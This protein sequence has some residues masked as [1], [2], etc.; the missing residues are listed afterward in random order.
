[1]KIWKRYDWR[2]YENTML[3]ELQS[4]GYVKRFAW[5]PTFVRD[6]RYVDMLIWFEWYWRYP[7]TYSHYSGLIWD[8]RSTPPQPF[9]NVGL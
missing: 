7:I 6:E 2:T 8:K 1:M 9:G 4:K 3:A 5:F